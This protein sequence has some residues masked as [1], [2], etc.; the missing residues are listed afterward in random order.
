M[1]VAIRAYEPIYNGRVDIFRKASIF[2]TKFKLLINYL[3][4][5]LFTLM[6]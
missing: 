4:V 2:I 3:R 5:F 6:A 1:I